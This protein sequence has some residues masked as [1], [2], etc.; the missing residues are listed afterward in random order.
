[1]ALC[2]AR[3]G[4]PKYV[5]IS[6]PRFSTKTVG[7][8]HAI[9]DHLWNVKNASFSIVAPTVTAGDDGG[10][11]W[12]MTE[13]I[14]PAWI[15]G[16]FGMKWV[17]TPKQK[18]TTKKLY[19][20]VTN[21]WGGKSH[22]QLDSLQYE[23][24]AAVRFKNKM[25]SG[26]YVSELSYYKKRKTFD[27]FIETLRGPDWTDDDLIFIGDTN[28]AEEGQD[29]WIYK[30][31]WNFRVDETVD[32][33][34]KVIQNQMALMEFTVE[35]N[36]FISK[37][38][39][40]EQLARY[41]HSEDLMARYRFG[42]WV[43]AAGDSVFFEVFRPNF[44][45][46]GEYET[47]VNRDPEILMPEENCSELGTGWDPGEINH[48]MVIFEEFPLQLPPDKG[49]RIVPAFK[50]LDEV[51]YIGLEATFSDFMQEVTE[52]IAEWEGYVGRPVRWINWSDRSAFDKKARL[53]DIYIHQE[54]FHYTEGKIRLQAADRSPGTVRQRVDLVKKL[55]F[56]GRLF[57]SRSRCPNLIDSFQSLKAGKGNI[58]IEK[59][60]RF[61]HAFDA[62][63]YYLA[64]MNQ[65]EL[66]YSKRLPDARPASG[67]VTVPL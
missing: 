66:S 34:A 5:L 2:R 31:W 25:H 45:I 46:V 4:K 20:E 13:H 36:I 29:S 60:S 67:I 59:D 24:E 12:L 41:S 53:S 32:A 43:R 11:W 48:A 54:V 40:D 9:A 65:T 7:C 55:L 35:D 38:R 42:R 50:A 14:L 17:N 28:P 39:L 19:C 37:E 3:P 15:N 26:M 1:M 18:G 44:H 47:P 22:L 64:S 8:L 23:N 58:A 52:K 21:K 63:S 16:N 6:G 49:S 56:E 61:K 27:Y 57:V 51:V 10:C 30:H 33:G 62:A